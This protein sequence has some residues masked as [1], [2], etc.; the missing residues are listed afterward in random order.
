M[1]VLSRRHASC[2][3]RVDL[4]R[5]D[6]LSVVK[7]THREDHCRRCSSTAAGAGRSA[8][9]EMPRCWMSSA[10]LLIKTPS[11]RVRA[12][13]CAILASHSAHMRRTRRTNFA[14]CVQRFSLLVGYLVAPL[15]VRESCTMIPCLRRRS[16]LAMTTS[17]QGWS[18]HPPSQSQS[19]GGLLPTGGV[20]HAL[21]A[22]L[23]GVP[24][25]ISYELL[26]LLQL[27][28]PPASMPGGTQSNT[29]SSRCTFSSAA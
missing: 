13:R 10:G 25:H 17:L 29:Q 28:E 22:P 5:R 9:R 15:G 3:R 14:T 20:Q 6:M 7:P 18:W 16:V 21:I 4:R 8:V 12:G 2:C 23:V 24:N 26:E 1:T 27:P 19:L 11:Q